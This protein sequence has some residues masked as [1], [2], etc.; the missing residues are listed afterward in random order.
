MKNRRTVLLAVIALLGTIFFI[1]NSFIHAKEV[2]GVTDKVIKI[3]VICDHTGPTSPFTLPIAK[4]IKLY[5]RYINEQGG[6]HGRELEILAEDDRYS[7]P[8]AI[9]AY[10]K[11]LHRDRIFALMGPGS[12]SFV[13]PLVGKFEKDKVPTIG[14][15]FSELNVKPHKRYVFIVC[16]TYEGQVATLTEYIV[17]DY[18][19]KDPRIGVVYPDTEAGKIDLRTVLPRLK[20]YG[21]EPVTKEIVMAGAIDASTQ[22]MSLRK[23]N[24]NYVM[25]I[26]TIPSTAVTLLRELR[27]FGMRVPVFNSWAAMLGED[28]N[29]IGEVASQAYVV[30]AISPWYGEG[31]GVEKM[32]EITLKYFPGTEKPYRGTSHTYGWAA[33]MV[34][35]EGLKRAGSDLDEDALIRA[36]EG[37]KNFDTGGLLNPLTFSSTSHKGGDSSRIY[38]ADPAAGK[39][40]AVTGWRKSE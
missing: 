9:S 24:V 6:I 29:E 33:G 3:G 40:V 32:R 30:H 39:F 13:P 8:A 7:I 26:G 34:L 4:G 1:N 22:V 16:D 11:L 23:N 38:R 10:K 12:G 5:A 37:F 25:N 2:R 18:K 19:L 17:K 36:F 28:L 20:K 21:I 15:P 35:V 31:P 27:K 14:L